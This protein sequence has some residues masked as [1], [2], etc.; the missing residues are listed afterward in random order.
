MRLGNESKNIS[1][2]EDGGIDVHDSTS[3]IAKSK[4]KISLHGIN[5]PTSVFQ[6]SWRRKNNQAAL[7][8]A[9]PNVIDG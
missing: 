3:T 6:E 2:G 8:F 9:I 4:S 5:V 7:S 1:V